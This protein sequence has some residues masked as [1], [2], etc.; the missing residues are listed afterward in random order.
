MLHELNG[1]YHWKKGERFELTNHFYT[2]DFD[3]PKALKGDIQ[4]ISKDLVDKLDQV[5]FLHGKPFRIIAAIMGDE[6]ILDSKE[7]FDACN[8]Y[9]RGYAVDI[10]PIHSDVRT[11]FKTVEKVFKSN[12]ALGLA[13]DYIHIDVRPNNEKVFR[14]S[15]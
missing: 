14:F 11:L 5:R 8:K 6:S 9:H 15:L 10:Q 13:K 3:D 1:F 7:L 12:C 2:T 4:R